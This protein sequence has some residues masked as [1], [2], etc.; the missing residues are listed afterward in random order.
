VSA[1]GVHHLTSE[2]QIAV[3][4]AG[5]KSINPMFPPVD[6]HL[7]TVMAG[8]ETSSDSTL[9]TLLETHPM[10]RVVGACNGVDELYRLLAVHRP[11]LLVIDA[12]SEENVF[13]LLRALSP[14]RAPAVIVAAQTATYAVR[15]FE[16]G[17]FEYLVKP[18][19][20]H[21]IQ[22]AVDRAAQRLRKRNAL[23]ERLLA[24][25][26]TEMRL[27]VKS[28]NRFVF[29]HA[30]EIEWIEAQGNKVSIHTEDKR[31][32]LTREGISSI[33][34]RLNKNQFLR[35]HRSY[36]VNIN[37]IAELQPCNNGEFIV[38]LRNGKQLPCS[39]TYRHSLEALW[40]NVDSYIVREKIIRSSGAQRLAG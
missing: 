31:S 19:T 16:A 38:L 5:V 11:D 23:D 4:N 15:A 14:Q 21:R 12:D 39:R 40:K 24:T 36:I 10:V 18:I 13:E 29:L 2:T 25:T 8:G 35:I 20:Q 1:T 9:R 26:A 34:K 30:G 27:V 37:R 33:V 32:Y 3:A 6:F 22:R 7:V 28:A 17:V